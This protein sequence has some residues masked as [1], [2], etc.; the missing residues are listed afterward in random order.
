MKLRLA[1]FRNRSGLNQA[2]VAKKIGKSVRTIKMWEAGESYPNAEALWNLCTILD[3]D[4]D[5]L[6]GWESPARSDPA[7]TVPERALLADYRASDATNRVSISI[8]AA[9]SAAAAKRERTRQQRPPGGAS[10]SC[11]AETA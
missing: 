7:L 8:I 6:L 10:A 2:E 1:E 3:T 4:P 9:N 5:S 11:D